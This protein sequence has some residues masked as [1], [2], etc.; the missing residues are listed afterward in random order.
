[1]KMKRHRFRYLIS[2]L[3]ITL[4]LFFVKMSF[5][6]FLGF[7]EDR[8]GMDKVYATVAVTETSLYFP[9]IMQNYRPPAIELT[10]ASTLNAQG[11]FELFF[12]LGDTVQY[13]SGGVNTSADVV[14]VELTWSLDGPCDATEFFR[15]TLNLSPGEWEHSYLGATPG[16]DGAFTATV[17]V[18]DGIYT[19]TL[20]T[21]FLVNRVDP[22]HGFDRCVLPTVSQL[23]TWWN[24]SPYTVW[25]IYLGGIHFPCRTSAFT[26][27]WIQA[28]A[29]QGW[30]FSL[31]WVGPQAPCSIFPF[32]HRFSTDPN[33]AYWQG[34]TEAANALSTA[35]ALGIET[36]IVIYYDLE[37]YYSTNTTCGNAVEAFLEGWT[38]RL[39]ADGVKAGAYASPCN[40]NMI[41]WINIPTPLDDIWI[42]H[43][44]YDGYNPAATV[45]DVACK[46][47]NNYWSNHQRLRQYSGD[48]TENWGGVVM[49]VDSNV[50]DGDIVTLTSSQAL[51]RS[52][53]DTQLA[54]ELQPANSQIR[55]MDLVSAQV[56]WVLMGK[57]LLLTSDGGDSWEEVRPDLGEAVILDAAFIDAD[58]GWVAAL[59]VSADFTQEV[60]LYHTT[61]GGVT[62]SAAVLPDPLPGVASA[63]MDFS[64]AHT[65]WV[66]LKMESGSS[67]SLGELFLTRDGGHTWEKR[68]VPLGEPLVFTDEQHGWMVGGP[69]GNQVYQTQDG[70][71]TWQPVELPGLGDGRVFIGQPVFA[72]PQNG[73]LPVTRWSGPT[74]QLVIYA[75]E[76]GGDIWQAVQEIELPPGFE[77][78]GVLPFS[79]QDGQW[80][81]ALPDSSDLFSSIELGRSPAALSAVGLP[82]GVISLDFVTGENGW[83][84]V[85]E[86]GCSGDKIPGDQPDPAPFTC[87]QGTRLFRTVDGGTRW[88]QI[89]P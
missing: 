8:I 62:W 88:S 2:V 69:A 47:P 75:T 31:A 26:P 52:P 72:T 54:V 22:Q 10:S 64:D 71:S 58:T 19:S 7:S 85:W 46:F 24:A 79:L 60:I 30:K 9:I 80:W 11:E 68:S 65:A 81:S 67:F 66:V 51:L 57:R 4:V 28:V 29:S 49:S 70:G 27:A 17:Q 44:I 18:D 25:N 33:T 35:L 15:D 63:Y 23:Q 48:Y 56:G 83:A 40:S 1:M 5:N 13:T 39:H 37:P 61:D 84:L 45:W 21:T 78:G 34:A 50:I 74:S 12:D 59:R 42:A 82:P 89:Y 73:V 87:S 36:D 55:D 43:W 53:L 3:L 38:E 16:C 76:N 14:P 77:P 20:T 41:E 6:G 86:G 32:A